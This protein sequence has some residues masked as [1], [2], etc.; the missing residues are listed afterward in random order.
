[1]KR[2][3]NTKTSNT[4]QSSHY[5][6]TIATTPLFRVGLA[7]IWATNYV[8]INENTPHPQVEFA[9]GDLVMAL[10][11]M[12]I[13]VSET[14]E[15][16]YTINLNLDKNCCEPESYQIQPAS[17]QLTI[18]AGDVNGLM[19]GVLELAELIRIGK[20]L[21]AIQPVDQKPYIPKRG[22]KFNIPLDIRTSAFDDSGDAAQKNIP[23]MWE[24]TFWEQFFD[25]MARNRYNMISFWNA[26]PFSSMVKLEDYPDVALQNV[27]GTTIEPMDNP[28]AWTT[29]EVGNVLP[30]ANLKVEKEMTIEEKIVFWQ[31]V[32]EYA[33][34]RGIDIYFIT[35]NICLN[36][37]APP[38]SNKEA[39]DTKGKYGITN[40]FQNP[41]SKDY[42]RKSVKQFLLNYP[43]VTG[44]GVTAGE[45]MRTPMTDYDKE[46]WLWETYGLGIL[47]A[48]KEQPDR[49]VNFIHRFWW[50]D[51]KE[52]MQFW[53]DYPDPFDMSFKYAKARLY[54]S[55]KTPFHK[56]L[57]DWMKPQGLKSWWNLRNDDIFI[58]RW[59]D[60]A[61]VSAFIKNMPYEQTAGFHMGSDGYVWGKEFIS[62]NPALSGQLEIHKHWY[63]FMLWGRLGYQPDMPSSRLIELIGAKFP[64]VNAHH[65]F[66][67]WTQASKII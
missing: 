40:D 9:K 26:H 58:H 10:E 20:P 53:G 42:L 6:K 13:K 55:P 57:L 65:L 28:R 60:P 34:N 16:A 11:E 27:C 1:M 59:G 36:G 8:H 66:D 3:F 49:T 15:A 30:V 23:I 62:K 56:P 32:M 29:P 17:N 31:E 48:K 5:V 61:Y 67:V 47:D 14:E 54:S 50:T 51:M 46:K 37:A 22:I 21:S 7:G 18:Q 33:H 38:G 19:Y 64:E 12:G 39:G 41:V 43:H 52:I 44:I 45:N 24:K 2:N 63:R 4:L 25:D 35:W